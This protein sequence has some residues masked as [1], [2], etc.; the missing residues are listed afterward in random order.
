ML[1]QGGGLVHAPQRVLKQV[2]L[3]LS[4]PLSTAAP[5]ST[6]AAASLRRRSPAQRF[7]T[8]QGRLQALRVV[9]EALRG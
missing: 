9:T 1:L 8:A 2:R 5:R 6:C 3:A 7:V 4:T